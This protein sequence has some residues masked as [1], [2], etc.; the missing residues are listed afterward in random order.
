MKNVFRFGDFNIDLIKY[1]KHS[2]KNEFIDSLFSDM[3]FPYILH[4]TRVT[5]YSQTINHSIFSNYVSKEVVCSNLTSMIF[6]HL[7]QV[8]FIPSVFSNH[9]AIKSN[10]FERSWTKFNQAEFVMHC[11]D[12]D[13]SNI[14]NPKHG[15]INVSTENLV[16]NMNDILDKDAH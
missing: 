12:K 9:P 11:F 4:P 7:L 10:I 5:G 14:L 2:R 8:L 1:D 13:W 15:N 3:F 6:D 16:T